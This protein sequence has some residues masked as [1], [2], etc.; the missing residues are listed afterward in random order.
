VAGDEQDAPS[1]KRLLEGYL[2]NRHRDNP[3][4]GCP[5]P[6]LSA[7]A[8]RHD[9]AVRS[10]FSQGIESLA[11][12]V[13]QSLPDE[14]PMARRQRALATIAC[15]AGAVSLARAVDDD[16]LSAEILQAAIAWLD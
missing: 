16:H 6:A 5:L 12:L 7:D 2:S 10:T 4:G 8:A 3:G 14:Q 11:E 13:A 9:P 15:L 1:L